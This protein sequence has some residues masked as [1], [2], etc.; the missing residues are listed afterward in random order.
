M[1]ATHYAFVDILKGIAI[2]LIVYG[3][4]TP[5]AV[6]FVTDY[7]STFHIPLFFFVSG[8]L[9][10]DAKYKNDFRSFAKNR[11]KGLVLP[12]L[13]FSIIVALGYFFIADDYL[14][15]LIHLLSS[16]W[17]AGYALW[18]LPV[19]I[20]VEFAYYSISLLGVRLLRLGIIAISAIVSYFSAQY[21]GLL[22]HN[23]LLV[24]CGLWFYGLGNNSRCFLSYSANPSQKRTI[25]IMLL[26][27]ILSLLYIP[28]S[29]TL[30]EWFINKIPSP[31]FYI[32]P[33]AATIGIGGVSVLISK[34]ST[35]WSKFFAICGKQSFIILAFHQI[36]CM[37]AQQYLPAKI[38]ILIMIIFLI[39]LVM[40]IPEYLPVMLGKSRTK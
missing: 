27:L 1:E 36:I 24:F 34:Y 7:V 9:Y 32:T 37:I 13:Y 19:L 12:F 29:N 26:G 33:V 14:Q 4:I 25:E 21:I 28:F 22:P 17:T 16:G 23:V 10:N 5:G 8:L 6:P 30:P 35:F 15:F 18:F 3:H 20:L 11:L 39:I 31:I 2:L 40:T 38:S